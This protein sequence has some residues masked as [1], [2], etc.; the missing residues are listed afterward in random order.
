MSMLKRFESSVENKGCQTVLWLSVYISVFE[1]S[2]ENKGCQTIYGCVVQESRFESSVENKG[3][4]TGDQNEV[5]RGS[6]RAV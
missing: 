2:V 4:Q 1:S 3:C 5:H 6:L